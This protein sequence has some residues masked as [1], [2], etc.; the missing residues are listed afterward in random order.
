MGRSHSAGMIL[1]EQ[2]TRSLAQ[3]EKKNQL[4]KQSA[5]ARGNRY[6]YLGSYQALGQEYDGSC[7][8]CLEIRFIKTLSWPLAPASTTFQ[9]A[10][11]GTWQLCKGEIPDPLRWSASPPKDEIWLLCCCYCAYIAANAINI[12]RLSSSFV[13]LLN[14]LTHESQETAGPQAGLHKKHFPSDPRLPSTSSCCWR[15]R[16]RKTGRY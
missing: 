2:C 8:V 5:A 10:W 9:S 1:P 14:Y 6:Q 16:A 11:E 13:T 15:D 4:K 12:H 7:S 3:G